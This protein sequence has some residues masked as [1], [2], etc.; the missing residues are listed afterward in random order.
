MLLAALAV[1]LAVFTVLCALDAAVLA[2][3][4]ADCAASALPFA[5]SAVLCAAAAL[6]AALLAVVCA[7]LIFPCAV[8]SRPLNVTRPFRLMA[9]ATSVAVRSVKVKSVALVPDLTSQLNLSAVWVAIVWTDAMSSGAGDQ[10][11]ALVPDSTL[12][13]FTWIDPFLKSVTRILAVAADSAV[14]VCTE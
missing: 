7:V 10:S 12:H 13:F 14:T 2:A 5:V 11:V 8:L 1:E 4:A 6:V 3:S 9:L